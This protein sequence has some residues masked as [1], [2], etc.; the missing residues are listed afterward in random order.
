MTV[1]REAPTAATFAGHQPRQ[2]IASVRRQ[3]HYGLRKL[4]TRVGWKRAVPLV[5]KVG[6]SAIASPTA[7]G[8][9]AKSTAPVDYWPNVASGLR[10]VEGAPG[11]ISL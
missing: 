8:V 4:E 9:M 11:A 6:R 3:S 10:L 1:C 5:G 2:P 7:T